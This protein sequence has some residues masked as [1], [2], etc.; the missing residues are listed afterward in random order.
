MIHTITELRS[1]NY[2]KLF[3]VFR[4]SARIAKQAKS[5]PGNITTQMRAKGL[6]AYTLTSWENM[7]AMKNFRNSGIHKQSMR[8]L[9]QSASAF[10]FK[11]WESVNPTNWE[12]GFEEIEKVE[13]IHT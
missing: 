7:D 10:R 12:E 8:S 5:T 3:G 11:T 1:K 9:F 2:W 6:I 4:Q 13:L